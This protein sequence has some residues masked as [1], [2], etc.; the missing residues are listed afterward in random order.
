MPEPLSDLRILVPIDASEAVEPSSALV[1]L[2][3]PHQLVVLGYYPV[4]DQTATDQ[5]REQFG[6]AATDHTDAIA[7]RFGGYGGGAESV[8]VFTH[9]RD[10]TIDNIADEYDVDAVL[11]PGA[12]GDTLDRILVPLRGDSNL[13]RILGFVGVLLRESDATATVYHVADSE[14][15]SS[16]GELLVRGACDQLVEDGSIDA[17]RVDWRNER[18]ESATDA[19]VDAATEHDLLIVGES[20]PSLTERILGDVTD[21]VIA[22]SSDPLLIVRD[23]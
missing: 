10:Q 22:E 9:D 21:S 2:L 14:E 19:I 8:V 15:D 6:E 18:A 17:D 1:E 20:E 7:E 5:A 4:P 3:H 16:R 12:V 13:E 23:R 11:T